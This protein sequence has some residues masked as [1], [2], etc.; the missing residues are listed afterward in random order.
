MRRYLN[1]R[2]CDQSNYV[3]HLESA[4]KRR[5]EE[6]ERAY[7][8]NR[9]TTS[10]VETNVNISGCTCRSINKRR[11]GSI[12]IGPMITSLSGDDTEFGDNGRTWF[13]ICIAC[14]PDLG[15][16]VRRRIQ[17]SS[18]RLSPAVCQAGFGQKTERIKAVI[19]QRVKLGRTEQR[20][21]M[22]RRRPCKWLLVLV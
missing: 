12:V 15:P 6:K 5:A 1:I 19:R 10:S 11:R 16:T 2:S 18:S 13:E 20:L 17:R 14:H 3:A 9:S 8:L 7:I 21:R 4:K 22:R